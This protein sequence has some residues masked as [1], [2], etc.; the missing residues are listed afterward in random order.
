MVGRSKCLG[1]AASRNRIPP[2]DSGR[3]TEMS[4]QTQRTAVSPWHL[5]HS[6]T[7]RGSV[8]SQGK[9]SAARLPADHPSPRGDGS[10]VRAVFVRPPRRLRGD[11]AAIP[12]CLHLLRHWC[13]T[14]SRARPCPSGGTTHRAGF[15]QYKKRDISLLLKPRRFAVNFV[16]ILLIYILY[17]Y[18]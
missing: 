15:G 1:I 16:K 5:W 7:V 2:R 17:N 6:E 14:R 9:P 18:L 13:H 4:A 3:H 11:V 12:P 10:G 8:F